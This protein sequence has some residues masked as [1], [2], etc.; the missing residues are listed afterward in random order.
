MA[1]L[2]WWL[3]FVPFFGIV[4]CLAAATSCCLRNGMLERVLEIVFPLDPTG[5]TNRKLR[6]GGDPRRRS[7]M[8]L[9]TIGVADTTPA[10]TTDTSGGGSDGGGVVW[11]ATP[12]KTFD[13][14]FD[15]GGGGV[16]DAGG[17]GQVGDGGGGGGEHGRQSNQ[18]SVPV[19]IE[20]ADIEG[21]G[22][23]APAPASQA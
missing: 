3:F 2:E 11:Y 9:I 21:T 15:G 10:D 1:E 7:R 6:R 14:I 22:M 8:L 20:V 13:G 18:V 19:V 4:S 12:A 17:D 5:V 16:E 23:S